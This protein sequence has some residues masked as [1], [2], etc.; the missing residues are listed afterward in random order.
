M[1][2][3]PATPQQIDALDK[4]MKVI[5]SAS[6]RADFKTNANDAADAGGVNRSLPGIQATVDHLKGLS[7]DQL[8]VIANLNQQMFSSG[9]IENPAST[10]LKLA[11][12][13]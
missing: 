11:K 10:T 13:V 4:L 2:T 9:L 3:L 5:T 8:K 6:T 1:A 7:D 12:Q